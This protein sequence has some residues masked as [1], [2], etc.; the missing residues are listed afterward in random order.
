M[1]GLISPTPRRGLATALLLLSA[2]AFSPALAQEAAPAAAPAPQAETKPADAKPAD[3]KPADAKP[4]APQWKEQAALDLL[5]AATDK[6]AAAKTLSVTI[7]SERPVA[8]TLGQFVTKLEET[9]ITLSRPERFRAK[10]RSGENKVE[11]LY[12]GDSLVLFDKNTNLYAR[13]KVGGDVAAMLQKAAETSA[14]QFAA[15]EFLLPD[16]YAVLTEGLANAY[17]VGPSLVDGDMTVQAVYAAPGLEWQLWVDPDTDLPVR[18][19]VTHLDEPGLPTYVAR[20]SDWDLKEKA[21]PG[22]FTF[23]VPK[24]AVE[25][26]LLP[27]AKAE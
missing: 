19:Q 3:A 7:E 12:D 16:P 21:G 17:V 15:A 5:K 1:M 23:K 4:D 11:Y 27:A 6:I 24:G 26:G 18:Y 9:D 14:I 2:A 8:T 13:L 22:E 20:F 25:I 10:V